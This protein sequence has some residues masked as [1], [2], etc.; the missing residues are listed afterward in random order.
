MGFSTSR[1]TPKSLLLSGTPRA[2]PS[3]VFCQRGASENCK[4]HDQ[5]FMWKGWGAWAVGIN[6]CSAGGGCSK[7]PV[8]LPGYFLVD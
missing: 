4:I 6:N 1:S 3:V 2:R 5:K 7:L 8:N